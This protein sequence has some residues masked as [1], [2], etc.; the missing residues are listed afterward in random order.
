V[1][2]LYLTLTDFGGS[3]LVRPKHREVNNDATTATAGMVMRHCIAIKDC[4]AINLKA[5]KQ[6]GFFQTYPMPDKGYLVKEIDECFSVFGTPC[7]Q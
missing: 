2:R 3:L 4:I 7:E 1:F 6:T 5:V